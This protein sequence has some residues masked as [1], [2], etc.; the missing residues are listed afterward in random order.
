MIRNLKQTLRGGLFGG[1]LGFGVINPAMMV[2]SD[3]IHDERFNPHEKQTITESILE[4]YEYE[5]LPFSLTYTLLSSL[6]FGALF[7]YQYKLKTKIEEVEKANKHKSEFLTSMSHDLRTPLNAIIGFSD[8]IIS[9]VLPDKNEEYVK[10]INSSGK[11]LLSLI[12]EILD[13]SRLEEGKFEFNPSVCSLENII[14]ESNKMLSNEIENKGIQYVQIPFQ[15]DDNI[16]ADEFMMGRVYYNV[17]GNA[18]KF[19]SEGGKIISKISEISD[20]YLEVSI[21]DTGIGI[22]K[23]KI[24]T[25]TQAFIQVNHGPYVKK[26]DGLGLGLHI[27]TELLKMHNS[28]LLIESEEG[29]GTTVSYL[30]PR[31][32]S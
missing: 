1:I 16:F 22:P 19:T 6:I 29:V 13:I 25:L 23:D 3:N 31:Y 30:V 21:T 15:G 27:S 28:Q 7:S 26:Y 10:D 5:F 8:T 24:E 9:G 32:K 18:I 4:S 2:L 12:N 20:N 11:H 17:L 14:N